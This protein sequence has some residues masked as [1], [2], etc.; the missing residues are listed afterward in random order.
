MEEYSEAFTNY[1]KAY[2]EGESSL[3]F[4]E[5]YIRFMIEEGRK[6][7]AKVALQEAL[8]LDPFNPEFIRYSFIFEE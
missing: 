2:E 5:D 4:Y 8:K 7:Q 1:Q 3:E 6:E